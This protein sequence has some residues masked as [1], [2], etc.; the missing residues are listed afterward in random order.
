MEILNQ[1]HQNHNAPNKSVFTTTLECI[2]KL[3]CIVHGTKKNLFFQELVTSN[4]NET[5][6]A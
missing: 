4:K 3:K 6:G 1:N 2:S 5:E